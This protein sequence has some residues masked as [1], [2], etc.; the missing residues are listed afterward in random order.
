MSLAHL[1]LVWLLTWIVHDE[2]SPENQVFMDDV[3]EWIFAR[4]VDAVQ[5]DAAKSKL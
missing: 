1:I 3:A 2:P 4:S 5:V